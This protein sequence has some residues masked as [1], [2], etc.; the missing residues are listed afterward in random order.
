M[1]DGHRTPGDETNLPDEK[2]LMAT[3]REGS[4]QGADVR[5]GEPEMEQKTRRYLPADLRRARTPPYSITGAVETNEQKTRYTR[6]LKAKCA[7]DV[8]TFGENDFS[9]SVSDL[10]LPVT[11]AAAPQVQARP[12][13][14][15][16]ASGR[17][18]WSGKFCCPC[19][20]LCSGEIGDKCCVGLENCVRFRPSLL[21][22]EK[23]RQTRRRTQGR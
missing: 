9:S 20:L 13:L 7:S 17:N 23:A 10:D 15:H 4:Q 5:Q 2:D 19:R 8:A 3:K 14:R 1:G 6:L 18:P 22:G 16:A 12:P 11:I 21:A